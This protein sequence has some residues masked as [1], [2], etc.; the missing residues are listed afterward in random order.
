MSDSDSDSDCLQ[1]TKR[2]RP[3]LDSS[4]DGDCHINDSDNI[5]ETCCCVCVC[6]GGGGGGG[7]YPNLI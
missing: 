5:D 6:V 1:L 4:V 7:G 3:Q 2:Y